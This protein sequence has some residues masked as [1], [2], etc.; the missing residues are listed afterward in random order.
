MRHLLIGPARERGEEEM[1]EG[2]RRSLSEALFVVFVGLSSSQST[3]RTM[4]KIEKLE[5]SALRSLLS[6]RYRVL[7]G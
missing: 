4:R 1:E 7:Q 3:P 6:S 5:P 2:V